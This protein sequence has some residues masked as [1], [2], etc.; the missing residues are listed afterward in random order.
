MDVSMY[1]CMKIPGI[2]SSGVGVCTLSW[3]G[4]L[5]F[6]NVPCGYFP[7]V[8]PVPVLAVLPR[9]RLSSLL[10]LVEGAWLTSQLTTPI[11]QQ[12]PV[13]AE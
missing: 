12:L 8:G 4:S 6:K 1:G 9:D 5:T 13:I 7:G 2:E 10:S 11:N 3:N